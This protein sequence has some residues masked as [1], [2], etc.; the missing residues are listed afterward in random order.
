MFLNLFPFLIQN[1][2]HLL[3]LMNQSFLLLLHLFFHKVDSLLYLLQIIQVLILLNLF[4][5]LNQL[6]LNLLHLFHLHHQIILNP[7]HNHK[8][9]L[10]ITL[11]LI[12]HIH[13]HLLKLLSYQQGYLNLIP[14]IFINLVYLG[15]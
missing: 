8:I 13:S 11:L 5:F 14:S 1:P 3:F 15:S 10:L 2:M 6:N 7:N 12:Y 4:Y 9:F